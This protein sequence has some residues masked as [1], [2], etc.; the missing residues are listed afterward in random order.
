MGWGSMGFLLAV[1]R[2]FLSGLIIE[3]FYEASAELDLLF[4][5]AYHKGFLRLLEGFCGCIRLGGFMV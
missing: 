5:K 1:S 3:G 4:Y 2:G